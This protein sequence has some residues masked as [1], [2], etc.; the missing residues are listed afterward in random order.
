[1]IEIAALGI[2][3]LALALAPWAPVVL[4]RRAAGRDTPGTP[5][6]PA[7]VERLIR[8]KLIVTLN[9]GAAFEGV[10]WEDDGRTWILRGAVALGAA[11]RGENLPVDGEL[12][13][14]VVDIAY[15]QKP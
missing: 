10:L 12:I 7:G 8:T 14:F 1:M 5:P 4:A 15:A 6:A 9:S 2:G 3:F 11:D 13:L